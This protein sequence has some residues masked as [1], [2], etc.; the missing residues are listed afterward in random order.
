MSE[1]KT[2]QVKQIGGDKDW[3][4]YGGIFL[5]VFEQGGHTYREVWNCIGL[6]DEYYDHKNSS[7]FCEDDPDLLVSVYRAGLPDKD[8][9]FAFAKSE[10][11]VD[12]NAVERFT[13]VDPVDYEHD[14]ELLI[15]AASYYGWMNFDSNP[16]KYTQSE[17][18]EV[19]DLAKAELF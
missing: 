9:K 4:T 2:I 17:L 5:R 19:L 15:D 18:E 3:W 7:K 8:D 1:L 10:T 11:W 6:E 13:G 12:W 16:T 14:Y